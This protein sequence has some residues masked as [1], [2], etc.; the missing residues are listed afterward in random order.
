M[1]LAAFNRLIDSTLTGTMFEARQSNF[2][3]IQM[4]TVDE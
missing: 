4:V 2:S 1:D 3:L